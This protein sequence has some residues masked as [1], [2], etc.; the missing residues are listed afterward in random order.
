MDITLE[1]IDQIRER[2]G[3]SLLFKHIS[4][5][6]VKF[7]GLFHRTFKLQARLFNISH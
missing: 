1:M 5:L 3:D 6:Y 4:G 2:T 7:I